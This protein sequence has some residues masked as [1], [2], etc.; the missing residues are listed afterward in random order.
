VAIPFFDTHEY[1]KRLEV[2]GIPVIQAE[3]HAVALAKAMNPLVTKS[4]FNEFRSEIKIEFS[5]FRAEVNAKFAAIETR[6]ASVHGEMTLLK[7]MLGFNLTGTIGI[8]LKLF[9]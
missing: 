9:H 2:S 1:V 7:W 3:A 8:L 6:F 5:E 4:D